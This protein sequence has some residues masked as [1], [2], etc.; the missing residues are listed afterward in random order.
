M[1][2][3]LGLMSITLYLAYGLFKSLG[4]IERL[5][6]VVIVTSAACSAYIF[7]NK[8]IIKRF[9]HI[10]NMSLFG[11]LLII[12]LITVSVACSFSFFTQYKIPEV[13]ILQLFCK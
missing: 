2:L 4:N 13:S 1:Y 5:I 12:V 7:F 6:N 3:Y 11:R 9:A 10:N 8:F